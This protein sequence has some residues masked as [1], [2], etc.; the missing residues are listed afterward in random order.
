VLAVLE[1]HFNNHEFCA[2]WCPSREGVA[3]EAEISKLGL[4]FRCKVRNKDMYAFMKGNHEQFMKDDKLRQ[5]FHE[6]DTQKVEGFNK[7]LTKFLPKDK[8]YC[9]TIENDARVHLA[10]GPVGYQQFYK[11]VFE[12]T[13]IESVDDD[14]TDLFF[15]SEDADKLFR[16]QYRQKK[17]V[18][19]RR[20]RT[21]FNKI[22]EGVEK[23]KND[24]EKSLAYNTGMMGPGGQDEQRE[25]EQGRR[26]SENKFLGCKWCQSTTHSRI[27]SKDCPKNPKYKKDEEG[28]E[29]KSQGK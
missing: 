26:G 7:L 11:R 20:M 13:R 28:S 19:I 14:I 3:T 9:R 17:E 23:L 1:H 8:T 6:Y 4:R 18:K 2:D 5:L 29:D 27:T 10:V 16:E 22:R 24:N 15:R 12:L 25:Q 21:H